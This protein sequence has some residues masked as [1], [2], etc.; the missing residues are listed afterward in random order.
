MKNEVVE[1]SEAMELT[2][3]DVGDDLWEKIRT[4]S[5][6]T[7]CE[8]ERIITEQDE[9]P[10][11]V[12]LSENGKWMLCNSQEC[13]GTIWEALKDGYVVIVL[14]PGFLRAV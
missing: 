8:Q 5:I 7:E 9:Y 6:E 4:S 14:R 10:Q 13:V 12:M 3:L 1:S 2:W 11:S